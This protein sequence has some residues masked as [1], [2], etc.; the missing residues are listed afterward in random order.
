MGGDMY[1][2]DRERKIRDEALRALSNAYPFTRFD[3]PHN[4]EIVALQ[5]F[6]GSHQRPGTRANKDQYNPHR[7]LLAKMREFS[8]PRQHVLVTYNVA[9]LEQRE[10]M[11]W[12]AK[13]RQKYSNNWNGLGTWS[14]NLLHFESLVAAVHQALG[15]QF[16]AVIPIDTLRAMHQAYLAQEKQAQE[17]AVR[18]K[19]SKR[20]EKVVSTEDELSQFIGASAAARRETI[21]DG[22]GSCFRCGV[23]KPRGRVCMICG[24]MPRSANAGRM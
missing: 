22:R 11:A 21:A 17:A 7:I 8:Q 10:D 18:V 16:P 6:L 9:Q 15:R 2:T 4:T 3:G 24:Y 20:T 19:T 12:F 14:V 23:P 5:F 13:I 1:L